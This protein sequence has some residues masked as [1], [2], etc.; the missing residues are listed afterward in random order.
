MD[1]VDPI[2]TEYLHQLFLG[3]K[4]RRMENKMAITTSKVV[5]HLIIRHRER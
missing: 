4:L 1:T 5:R 3:P 2:L